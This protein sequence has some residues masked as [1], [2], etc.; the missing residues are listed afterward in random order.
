MRRLFVFLL[1]ALFIAASSGMSATP[2]AAQIPREDARRGLIFAG[3]ERAGAS[4]VCRGAF[5]AVSATHRGVP[6]CTHGPDP[7]PEGVDVQAEVGPPPVPAGTAMATQVPCFGNGSDGFRVQLI[8]AR[9]ADKADGYANWLP[10]FQQWAAQVDDVY[11]QSAAETGGSRHI[12][13]VHDASCVAAVDNVVLSTRGDDTFDSMLSE[14]R[15]KGYSRTDRKYLVWMDANVYC[16]IGQVYYDDSP[17]ED[18][19]SNGNLSVPG[20]V[21][22]VDK[23]CWGLGN[24]VE[25]HELVHTLG[26]V[27]T[28][29]PNA[30]PGSH[31]TDE[32]DRLCYSDGTGTAVVV[33]SDPAHE[34]RL[35]CNHDDYYSTAPAPGS[36]L[37]T[38]WNI[39]NSRFLSGSGGGPG[40]TTTTSST[41]PA[42]TTTTRF[43]FPFPYPYPTTT[44]KPPGTTTS[45]STTTTQPTATT[46]TTTTTT[47]GPPSTTTTTQPPPTSSRP[48][49]PQ[50]LFA[51]QPSAAPTGV[52]LTWGAPSSSGTPPFGTY[53]I[54]RG[55]TASNL[56]PIADVGAATRSYVDSTAT[57]RL[58]WWY[59][60][61]AVNSAGESPPSNLAR[62][63]AK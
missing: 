19:T 39:A 47:T 1:P 44:T 59:Y 41:V 24:M 25:A 58:V 2:V 57:S 46:T 22:R 34:N 50:S 9:A 30:T 36:Y 6:V 14:L 5:R 40:S 27:Q 10:S 63:V 11:N 29:A 8:Y 33:C 51:T 53:R 55:T 52:A 18:N 45:T 28:S 4:D 49:A 43:R 23:A 12:R 38:H 56:T 35:D 54:Y 17:G 62:M 7:A 26:G 20:E 48:S 3:L 37:D 31:C 61:T 21:G 60:V 42:T 13:F 16:G 15:A 32:Y